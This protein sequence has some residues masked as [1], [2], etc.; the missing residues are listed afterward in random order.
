MKLQLGG[1][2]DGHINRERARMGEHR[3]YVTGSVEVF[4]LTLLLPSVADEDALGS[5]FLYGFPDPR[6]E[7][8]CDEAGEQAA[9]A[10]DDLI[11]GQ[12]RLDR[13]GVGCRC[14][15]VEVDGLDGSRRLSDRD[16]SPDHPSGD[17]GVQVHEIGGGRVD[18]S[19]R[20]ELPAGRGDRT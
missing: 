20:L 15:W 8:G 5:R 17:A 14:G 10:H 4:G 3:L 13:S 12:D 16:L 6:D 1:L 18:A 2:E 11:G 7:Q 9:G 19:S